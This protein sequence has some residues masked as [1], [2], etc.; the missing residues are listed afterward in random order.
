MSDQIKKIPVLLLA[1]SGLLLP[2]APLSARCQSDPIATRNQIY[3]LS[4]E[5]V[6]L[7]TADIYGKDVSLTLVKDGN[8]H[9]TAWVPDSNINTI[10]ATALRVDPAGKFLT[11]HYAVEPWNNTGDQAILKAI[12]SKELG[13]PESA[14]HVGGV[15]RRIILRRNGQT[16][17]AV[18]LPAKGDPHQN[19]GW[20]LLKNIAPADSL[21]SAG[22]I[23]PAARAT[24]GPAAANPQ[25]H[26][27]VYLYGYLPHDPDDTLAQPALRP[28]TVTGTREKGICLE[29]MPGLLPE[30]APVFT[31]KGALI[32]IY[33]GANRASA[34]ESPVFY[35][36]ELPYNK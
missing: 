7:V 24:Q 26:T 35:P 19:M 12:F 4:H 22:L 13:L 10:C 14:I 3:L 11:S 31:A 16:T 5:F 28:A 20:L 27:Q 33:S 29:A 15:S 1:L 9:F 17:E 32:G 36:I 21:R 2:L 8:M 30:G 34:T 25:P 18:V 23:F 6:Y